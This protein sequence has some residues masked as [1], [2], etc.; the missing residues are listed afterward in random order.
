[1]LEEMG[2]DEDRDAREAMTFAAWM[3]S[4]VTLH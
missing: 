1:M 4:A 2:L 3:N